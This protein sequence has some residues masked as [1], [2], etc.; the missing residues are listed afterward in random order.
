[1]IRCV[2][3]STPSFPPPGT[4]DLRLESGRDIASESTMESDLLSN[5]R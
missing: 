2:A 5:I 3:K 1:M 4:G